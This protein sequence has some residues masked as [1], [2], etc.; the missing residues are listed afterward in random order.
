MFGCEASAR[1]VNHF[2][3]GVAVSRAVH[4]V[5]HGLEEQEGTVGLRVV[6]DAGRV[7]VEHLPPEHSL[8]AADVADAGEQ[9]LKVVAAPGPLEP[10][11]VHRKPLDEL[12]AQ[13]LGRSDA[14]LR[15]AMRPDA[16]AGG[17]ND[18]KVIVIDRAGNLA[19]S[20]G[21]NYPKSPDSCR[22]I[23]QLHRKC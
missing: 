20:L 8:A 22:R 12:V 11:I 4:L 1:Q 16:I 9:F 15:A 17:Q 21:L 18:V 2:S 13:P 10:G 6:V 5:L 7:D 23:I 14:K 3:G 19:I